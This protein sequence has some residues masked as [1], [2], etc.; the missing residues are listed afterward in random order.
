[1]IE[2]G[3]AT[4]AVIGAL[5][6][7]CAFFLWAIV[8]YGA[9]FYREA[10]GPRKLSTLAGAAAVIA[11]IINFLVGTFTQPL[12]KLAPPPKATA[13]PAAPLKQLPAP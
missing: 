12:P 7:L 9:L 8:R 2:H 4:Y 11:I 10:R 6:I 13:R 1:M 3:F 5:V